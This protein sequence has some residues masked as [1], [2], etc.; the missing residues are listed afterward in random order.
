MTHPRG[1]QPIGVNQPPSGGTN[2]PFVSPSDDV[3]YLLGDFYLAYEDDLR[4]YA[5]PFCIDWMYGF[6]ETIN[7]G[8]AGYPSPVYSHDLIVKDANGETVFDSTEATVFHA[9]PWANRLLILEWISASAVCRCTMHTAWTQQDT[10][11]GLTID[12]DLYIQPTNGILDARTLYRTPERLRSIIVGTT[13][14]QGETIVL[15]SGYNVSIRE[16]GE[17]PDAVQ[18]IDFE[19]EGLS[20]PVT[21]KVI[22]G[23]RA[24]TG[25]RFYV[26][27][28]AGLGRVP[29]CD[30]IDVPLR[31]ING[32]GPNAAGNVTFDLSQ[33]L[34]VQRP[35]FL[36]GDN[37]RQFVYLAS[38]ITI[39][40]AK[41]ALEFH[42]DCGPCCD[43]DFFVRTY[44]GLSRL[45]D[46]GQSLASRAELVRDALERNIGRWHEQKSC[47]AQNALRTVLIPEYGCKVSVGGSYCNSTS[48]CIVPLVFRFTFY[49]YRQE[50][51][52]TIEPLSCSSVIVNGSPIRPEGEQAVLV[53]EWPVYEVTI[54]YLNPREVATA[55]FR[56]CM[57]NCLDVDSLRCIVTVHYPDLSEE[58]ESPTYAPSS[59]LLTLWSGSA[60][61]VPTLTTRAF[62]QTPLV[63]LTATSAYCASCNCPTTPLT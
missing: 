58:C 52:T 37:P 20:R 63:P 6:G 59:A 32:I 16:K 44:K 1:R 5:M 25:V 19:L 60:L 35:V 56:L 8:P 31:E 33:C 46:S 2:Y 10:D 12:Y 3:R 57:P 22:T 45:W 29:G 24:T 28:G 55:S 51:P 40:E 43:C 13:T 15:E 14:L 39:E 17:D 11:D 42:N 48:C 34:R 27:A 62:G 49:Y 4:A 61:G 36:T 7:V 50:V 54:D 38:G 21:K 18:D 23:S 26:S 53:G 41:S 9:V 30:Q 47:R